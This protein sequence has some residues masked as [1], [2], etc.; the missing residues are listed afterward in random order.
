MTWGIV[1]LAAGMSERMGRPKLLLPWSGTSVIGRV[2]TTLSDAMGDRNPEL[3]VITGAETDRIRVEVERRCRGMRA[4][5]IVNPD[6]RNGEMMDSL[7][8]GLK[9][10]SPG[11]ERALVVLGDQP[12]L[13]VEAA[14]LVIEASE[15]SAAPIVVPVHRGRRGHPWSIGRALWDALCGA[16]T[17]RSFLDARRVDIEETAADGTVLADLDTPEDYEREEP[18][19]GG[20]AP[21]TSP[22]WKAQ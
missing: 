8:V 18:E 12:Q 20:A 9:K 10:L 11:V 4:A 16:A 6:Y 21:S 14:R 15:R 2:L 3:A 5:C 19:H 22:A 13:S 17:A 1:L 7:R